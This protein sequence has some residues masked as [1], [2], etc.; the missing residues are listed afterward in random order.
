MLSARSVERSATIERGT[1][2]VFVEL[3]F[4][5]GLRLAGQVLDSGAPVAGARLAASSP[6]EP[7]GQSTTTDNQGRF[8]LEGLSPGLNQVAIGAA[9]FS[10]ME[11][12]SIEL[13]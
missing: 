8:V 7:G 3:P 4:E 11:L 9:D 13:Q 2:E 1:T 12:R 6:G 5:R 10:E